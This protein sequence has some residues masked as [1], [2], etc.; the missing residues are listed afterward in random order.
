MITKSQSAIAAG[1]KAAATKKA[2]ANELAKKQA[3]KNRL[4]G[5]ASGVALGY[6]VRQAQIRNKGK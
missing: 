5:A 6:G 1:K 2:N 4:K 3:V